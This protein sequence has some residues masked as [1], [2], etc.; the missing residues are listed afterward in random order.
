MTRPPKP[1]RVTIDLDEEHHRILKAFAGPG[2]SAQILRALLDEM[3]ANPELETR[4]LARALAAK[5]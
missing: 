3:K 5:R 1:I 4:I 2:T